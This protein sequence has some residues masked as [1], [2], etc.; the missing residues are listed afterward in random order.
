MFFCMQLMNLDGIDA[1]TAVSIG[2]G[3]PL[4]LAMQY[5]ASAGATSVNILSMLPYRGETCLNSLAVSH[6]SLKIEVSNAALVDANLQQIKLPQQHSNLHRTFV[7]V[8][9]LDAHWTR[10]PSTNLSVQMATWRR[11]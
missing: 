2:C 7:I 3:L 5:I 1:Q 8:Q 6:A 11:L 9:T 10:D 4:D